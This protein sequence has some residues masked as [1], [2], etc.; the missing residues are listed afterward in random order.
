MVISMGGHQPVEHAFDTGG[1]SRGGIQL[2]KVN[3]FYNFA[4]SLRYLLIQTKG[5]GKHLKGDKPA[6]VCKVG[7]GHIKRNDIRP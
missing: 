2:F 4:H 3:G 5:F 6:N 1:F 7:M